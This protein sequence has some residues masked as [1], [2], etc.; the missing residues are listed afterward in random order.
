MCPEPQLATLSPPICLLNL[1]F[2]VQRERG[3]RKFGIMTVSFRAIAARAGAARVVVA[4]V[5][6]TEDVLARAQGAIKAHFAD[7]LC[8]E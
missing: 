7:A 3:K 5:G 1:G 8:V 4:R 2:V 6:A